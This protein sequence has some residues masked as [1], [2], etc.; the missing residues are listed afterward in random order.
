MRNGLLLKL[1]GITRVFD[2][3]PIHAQTSVKVMWVTQRSSRHC[4]VNTEIKFSWEIIF[5]NVPWK[6]K[7]LVNLSDG[8]N[9]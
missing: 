2:S 5:L 7:N 1:G 8:N 9:P 4:H 3:N 6:K